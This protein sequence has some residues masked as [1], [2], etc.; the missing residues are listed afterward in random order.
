M[1]K[2]EQVIPEKRKIDKKIVLEASENQGLR[3]LEK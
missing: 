3:K 1:K 2:T